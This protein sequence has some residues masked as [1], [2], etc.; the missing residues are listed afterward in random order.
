MATITL[1]NDTFDAQITKSPILLVD[2]WAPWCGPCKFF[3]PIFDA[4]SDKHTDATF[5][6]VDTD[7]EQDLAVKLGIQSIPTLMAFKD[8]TLVFRQAGAINGPQLEELLTKIK[9]FDVSTITKK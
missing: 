5:A 4:A 7:V 2:F 6:K 3:G 9:A 8:G 1:T